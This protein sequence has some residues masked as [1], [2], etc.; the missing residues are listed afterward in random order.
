MRLWEIVLL[1]DTRVDLTAPGVYRAWLLDLHRPGTESENRTRSPADRPLGVAPAT[2]KVISGW[3]SLWRPETALLWEQGVRTVRFAIANTRAESTR[4]VA[5]EPGIAVDIWNEYLGTVR[6]VVD[7][8]QGRAPTYHLA[9][10]PQRASVRD[11][12]V[13]GGK[14]FSPR[15][16]ELADAV[17]HFLARVFR[18]LI[19]DFRDEHFCGL[20]KQPVAS[21]TPKG[22]ESRS[23]VCSHC[24]L[25]K[26]KENKGVE[27]VRAVWR[28]S[29]SKHKPDTKPQD[30][31]RGRKARGS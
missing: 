11:S 9:T 21:E 29:K 12:D 20:C 2:P 31:G 30:G 3:H 14:G 7:H 28:K 17:D 13:L 18:S 8:G 22:R 23:A 4:P 19:P 10:A 15:E 6:V 26:W 16:H 24:A 25:R 5:I 27:G 1:E